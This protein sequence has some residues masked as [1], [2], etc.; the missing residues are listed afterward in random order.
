M[1]AAWAGKYEKG[2]AVVVEEFRG[3][4]VKSTDSVGETSKI[5]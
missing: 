5:V 4:A 1:E 2:F 3:F